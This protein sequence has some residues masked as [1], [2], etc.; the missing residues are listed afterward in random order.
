MVPPPS[1]QSF[2]S[3]IAVEAD[4]WLATARDA[5]GLSLTTSQ[6]GAGGS[7][8]SAAADGSFSVARS[9]LSGRGSA[10]RGGVEASSGSWRG[11][12]GGVEPSGGSGRSSSV[13]GAG[14][15]GAEPGSVLRHLALRAEW[16][17][18]IGAKERV[19][20]REFWYKLV[21][22]QVPHHGEFSGLSGPFLRSCCRIADCCRRTCC[23]TP[24]VQFVMLTPRSCLAATPACQHALLVSR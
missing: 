19:P 22:P 4:M 3:L 13:G 16:Q 18:R 5:S 9:S 10:L 20:W 24:D 1:G 11:P 8:Q 15:G 17:R 2:E 7:L 21:Q 6:G 12:R 14:G 23:H